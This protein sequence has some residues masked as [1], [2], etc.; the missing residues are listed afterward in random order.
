V[1]EQA[2]RY[3]QG[4]RNG[5]AAART[6]IDFA[7]PPR[8]VEPTHPLHRFRVKVRH[9]GAARGSRCRRMNLQTTLDMRNVRFVPDLVDGSKSLALGWPQSTKQQ[10]N[11][12]L[13]GA[14]KGFA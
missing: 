9:G 13:A 5:S 6:D 11:D 7:G 14:Q 10:E 1:E 8:D 12:P 2:P 3:Q 4:M